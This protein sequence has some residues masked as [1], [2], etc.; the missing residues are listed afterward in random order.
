MIEKKL[1]RLDNMDSKGNYQ[2]TIDLF[3]NYYVLQYRRYYSI[4]Y[5]I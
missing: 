3:I 1:S 2:T 5:T 4:V